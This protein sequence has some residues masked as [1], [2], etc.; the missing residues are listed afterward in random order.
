MTTTGDT[1]DRLVD[2]LE[3]LARQQDRSTLARLRRSLD[4][5]GLL[6]GLPIVLPFVRRDARLPARAEDDAL[7]LAGLFA[8]HPEPG[9]V[10]L[11]A[12]L[13]RAARTSDS[14]T[15][16]FRAL[17]GAERRDLPIHLRHAVALAASHHI[18][19]D[20][21]TLHTAIRHWDH[22]SGRIRRD[23]ARTFWSPD[24]SAGETMNA[25]TA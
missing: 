1:R 20:W 2:Y 11:P 15:L 4:Q 7:L 22:P 24:Q 21:R 9:S 23:W 17:L 19:I 25:A 13:S 12:A 6:D 14:I 16:R 3:E 5:R 10:T 18:A 8:L